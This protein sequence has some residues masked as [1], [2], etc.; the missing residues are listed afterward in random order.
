MTNSRRALAG[1][2][3]AVLAIAAVGCGDDDAPPPQRPVQPTPTSAATSGA[4]GGP[5]GK[6]LLAE[7]IHI[8]E[9]VVCPIPDKPSDPSAKCDLKAPSCAEH[10]YC[11]K[12]PQ[13]SFCEPC[14]ER[15]AIRHAFKERDFAA[16]QNRDPFQSFLLPQIPT[17][18]KTPFVPLDPTKKCLR[19]DQMVA[20]NY[21]Y[22]DL[23]LVGIVAAGTQRKVLM[24]V[25]R[26]GYIIKRGDCVGKEKAVVK[27]I[28]A[29]YVTF[30]IDADTASVVQ[31][32]PQEY[33][34]A[35]NPK[36]LTVGD[37]G[38]LPSSA[39]RT[40]ITP[41]VPPPAV[42]PPRGQPGPPPAGGGSGAAAPAGGSGAAGT[43]PAAGSAVAPPVEAPAP[44]KKS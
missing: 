30:Q 27:D 31:R 19:N 7:K 14:P 34:V 40:T 22:A 41:V 12:L 37:P 29:G 25:G 11:L 10:L 36:Q 9:R 17:G 4:A 20:S 16:E 2:A 23:K 18:A 24:T 21:G 6:N 5:G 43:T 33:S 38:D 35:L 3:L 13:G 8:E 39:P 1:A 26:E 15:D 28:G 42:L 32:P 44:A